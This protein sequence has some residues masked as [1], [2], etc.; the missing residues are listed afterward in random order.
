MI[1]LAGLDFTIIPAGLWPEYY[2]VEPV[3]IPG[4]GNRKVSWSC[5]LDVGRIIPHVL[6]HPA[7]E[8]RGLSRGGYRLPQLER[9][10]RYSRAKAGPQG[11]AQVYERRRISS[12]PMMRRS[13]VFCV[14]C[15][16]PSASQVPNARKACRC[17]PTGTQPTCRSSRA[18]PMDEV[19]P[20]IIEPAV[21]MMENM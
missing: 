19:F 1:E 7:F 6:A 18:H 15:C 5:G 14:T 3:M 13:R 20:N 4:D 8:K 10:A 11:G 16:W 21:K 9:A 2:M 12:G 17:G